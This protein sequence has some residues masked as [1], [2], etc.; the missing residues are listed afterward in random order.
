MSRVR[1]ISYAITPEGRRANAIKQAVDLRDKVLS[2][3]DNSN[4]SSST[5]RKITKK[6]AFSVV[7]RSLEESKGLPLSLREHLAMKELNKYIALAKHNKSDFF[8]ATNTDLLPISHP[9]STREHSMTASALR[10]ARSRWFAADPRI[11]DER[12]KAVLASAFE[13]IPGSVE[14]LYY[15]SILLS[16]PQGT[17]PGEALIAA[18]DGNSSESRSARARRQRRDS[19]GRFAYEG[20]GIRALIRRLNGNVFS[21]S[22]RVVANAKNS[23]DV[24]VEFPDGKIAEVNPVKGEYIKAVLPTPDG[25]SPEPIIPSVTDEVIDEKDLVFV[26]APNGWEKD[27]DYKEFGDKVERYVDS[28]KEFVVFVSKQD[29]GTKDYQILNA[30]SAEQIDV[31]KT[32]ADVQD[33]LEGKE[34]QILNPEAKLPFRQ[35]LIPAEDRP[36]PN[37]YEKLMAEKKDK[38]NAIANRKAELKKNADDRVDAL[39]RTVPEDWAIEEKNNALMLRRA[40]EPADLENVYKQDNFVARVVEQ[41]E[42]SVKDANNL[43]EDKVYQNWA[44][45]DKDKDARATEYAQKA[46]E[47]IKNFAAPYGY[48]EEDLNKID[49]M[50]ADEI[51]SFFLD[52]RLQP[53]GFASA[54]DDYMNSAMVDAPSKQQE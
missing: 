45:V 11:T 9:R 21:L 6:A 48:K 3:V 40:T 1:R 37:A 30:K 39:D 28:N 17:I 43:L 27:E 47:E 24:E 33:R 29:D 46:R 19:K 8:Y 20:G 53:E 23:R 22:G 52:E 14:H 25:Y 54:L 12:A 44:Y 10:I 13:S 32:W 18:S 42:I 49:S 16:L 51:A 26:D 38:E 2:I 50:S 34:D 4:F 15:T 31:V 5:A 7:M 35:G 36:G 41:G